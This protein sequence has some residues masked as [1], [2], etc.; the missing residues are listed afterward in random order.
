[1]LLVRKVEGP[2]TAQAGE[3]VTYRATAFNQANPSEADKRGINWLIEADGAEFRRLTAA[4]AGI[5]FEIPDELI[6]RTLVVMPF[7]NSPTR[8]VS[9]VTLVRARPERVL[10]DGLAEVRRDFADILADAPP[11]GLSDAALAERVKGLKFALDDLLDGAGPLGRDDAG[12]GDEEPAEDAAVSRLAIIVGHTEARSG[13]RA[14]PPIDQSE[15]P[16]NKE[17]ARRMELAAEN[18]GI[19][20]HTFFRD[21]VGIQG[22]YRAAAAIQPAGIIELHFNAATSLARGSETLCCELHPGSPRL[23]AVVQRAMVRVFERSG[24]RDRGVKVLTENDRGFGNV[25]AAPGV[26]SVLVEPFFGSNEAD[27]RLAHERVGAYAEG[28]V[29]AFESFAAGSLVRLSQPARVFRSAE[30]RRKLHR[31]REREEMP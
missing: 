8:A 23:A 20:A 24:S 3:S 26:P 1:M 15:Y 11:D 2:A 14:L 18:R 22:A 19:A 28:L 5:T 9:A 4:G 6:G 10:R 7:A 17:V 21:G 12:D 27:C 16:F 25:S 13:A 29:A 30:T 31:I